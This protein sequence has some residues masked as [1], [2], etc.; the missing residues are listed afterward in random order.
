[1]VMRGH[2]KLDS[3]EDPKM[4][5]QVRKLTPL[6][7]LLMAGALEDLDTNDPRIAEM[8]VDEM[9]TKASIHPGGG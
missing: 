3:P 6:A 7:R 8:T 5:V 2:A 1:M 4:P 9:D